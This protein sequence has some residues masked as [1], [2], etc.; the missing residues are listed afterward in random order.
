MPYKRCWPSR[1][2]SLPEHATRTCRPTRRL[3]AP[4]LPAIVAALLLGGFQASPAQAGWGVSF[5]AGWG[6][7]PWYGG[8]WYGNS[9]Y[10]GQFTAATIQIGGFAGCGWAGPAFPL[11][12][13]CAL[14]PPPVILPPIFL[15]SPG[16]FGPGPVLNMLYG[17]TVFPVP[18]VAGPLVPPG[19]DLLN[20][21]PL[22]G[23]NG[24]PLP[25]VR[26]A[27]DAAKA[28]ARRF[29]EMGNRY[30]DEQNFR[31][32]YVRYDKATA[33]APDLVEAQLLKGQSLIAIGNFEMAVRAFKMALRVD[34]WTD[35]P[36]RWDDVY[37]KNRVAKTAHIENLAEAAHNDPQNPDLMLLLGM[38]L[39]FD[40]QVERSV[41]FFQR[42]AAL[43]DAAEAA[44][45]VA[46]QHPALPAEIVA[47][48]AAPDGVIE[49]G[50]AANGAAA[51]GA[52]ADG[53]IPQPVNLPGGGNG[54]QPPVDN[55]PRPQP[56]P[57]V[58]EARP[59]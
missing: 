20:E 37:G 11:V 17:P 14:P 59:F 52:A 16:I 40:G 28:R 1:R 8:F 55:R 36:L 56:P 48:G 54:I 50:A 42:Y 57:P 43:R 31:R 10:G 49:N 21:R 58:N 30:F 26:V 53:A 41:K 29:I 5:Q 46:A 35:C 19:L 33:A 51:N 38:E 15:P 3:R 2:G 44:G 45:A 12:P 34:D 25:A 9:W 23:L 27:N 39:F 4:L 13:A 18:G 47:Q 32:A 22:D 6:C 24:A 7:S